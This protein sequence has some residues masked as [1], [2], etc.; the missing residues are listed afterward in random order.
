[1]RGMEQ[2]EQRLWGTN[3]SLLLNDSQLEF[4]STRPVDGKRPGKNHKFKKFPN[5]SWTAEWVKDFVTAVN[6]DADP[7]VGMKEAWDNLAFIEAAYQSME[8]GRP[9]DIRQMP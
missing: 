2:A 3:G 4:Y 8:Q 9:V 6:S 1:M 5:T 7:S